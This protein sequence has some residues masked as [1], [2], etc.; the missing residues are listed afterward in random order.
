MVE[1]R[2]IDV[3][4]YPTERA[5]ILDLA[6]RIWSRPESFDN[7]R[8]SIER[9]GNS[10]NESGTYFYVIK[11]DREIGLTGYYVPSLERGDFGLRHHGTVIKGTGK[12]ALDALLKYLKQAYGSHFRRLIELIP[13]GRE[14]LIPKFEEWG[15]KLSSD[16]IP[17]WEPKRD[18]YKYMMVLM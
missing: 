12:L 2:K 10:G 15:F 16:P 9:W 13:E 7:A 6:G 11:D 1:L 17:E 4:H 3:K 5:K 8:D 18:Y 14:E